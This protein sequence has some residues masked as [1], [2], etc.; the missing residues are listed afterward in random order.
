MTLTGAILL[1]LTAAAVI[2]VTGTMLARSADQLADLTGWG[3][4]L[5]GAV[6]LGG[7]TSLPGIVTSV[8]AALENHP[9]LAVSNAIGGIAAQTLFLC[10]ADLSYRQS[11]LEHAAASVT[12]LMQ[13]ILLIGLLSLVLIGH[14]GPEAACWHI[15]PLSFFIIVLYLGGSALIARAKDRPMWTPLL[16]QAT[17][18]D[19]PD[20]DTITRLNLPGVAIKFTG[21]ALIVAVAGYTVGQT[22]IFIADQTG[23][24]EGLVGTLFT[25]VASSLPELIVSIAAVRQGALTLAVGNIIGGNSFDVLFVAFADMAYLPGSIL[26]AIGDDQVFFIA[27]TL[28]LTS[29]L[30]LGLLHREK[31]GIAGIGWESF[32]II[33]LYFAGNLFLFLGL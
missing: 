29:I 17:V 18:K 3:E 8:V 32:S 20:D 15:H 23:L 10:I 22:G 33:V 5:L 27:L 11:N 12:N 16:T 30:I 31:H 7:V 28:L 24:S 13:G 21:L 1:F 9:Q 14:A 6:F 19:I 2:A 4:A 25:A 26:H